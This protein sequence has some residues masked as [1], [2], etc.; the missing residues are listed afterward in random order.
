MCAELQ[1]RRL[2]LCLYLSP[3]AHTQI[4]KWHLKW[5]SFLHLEEAQLIM[6]IVWEAPLTMS[7]GMIM[8]HIIGP[9]VTLCLCAFAFRSVWGRKCEF[10]WHDPKS[11]SHICTIDGFQMI[12]FRLF[13]DRKWAG[14]PTNKLHFKFE[15]FQTKAVQVW[16]HAEYITD[17]FFN[18]LLTEYHTPS[19]GDILPT[20]M[21][22]SA[23][24]DSLDK[25]TNDS[26]SE[27]KKKDAANWQPAWAR[28]QNS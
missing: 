12:I 14:S 23:A 10:V 28:S 26:V 3:H 21:P 24:L 22:Q 17:F 4:Y 27:R 5:G 13:K 16:T 15:N 20:C 11:C 7:R 6:V 2:S 1:G 25:M 19:E 18:N 9:V 8:K